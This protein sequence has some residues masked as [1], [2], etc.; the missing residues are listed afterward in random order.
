MVKVYA[1]VVVESSPVTVNSTTAGI[2][3][4]QWWND[5]RFPHVGP[6]SLA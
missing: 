6:Q 5:T 1:W 4:A 2:I 3:G